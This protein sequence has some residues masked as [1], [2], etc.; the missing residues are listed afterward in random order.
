MVRVDGWAIAEDIA[1]NE[2]TEKDL[3][4]VTV[5][6]LHYHHCPTCYEK[7]EC[8]MA[9][10]IEP[11]L[12]AADGRQFGAHCNCFECDPLPGYDGVGNKVKEFSKEWWD[13]YH[14]FRK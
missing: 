12:E 5:P 1:I 3:I 7:F 4:P 9:C 14:G 2:V 10:T 11:D 13:R 6:S 8:H